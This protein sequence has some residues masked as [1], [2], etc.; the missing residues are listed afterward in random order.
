MEP[1]D[2]AAVGLAG[3]PVLAKGGLKKR[4]RQRAKVVGRPMAQRRQ[5]RFKPPPL[6]AA[7]LSPKKRRFEVNPS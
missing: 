6:R 1:V 5:L 3:V 4:R 7:Q 2:S